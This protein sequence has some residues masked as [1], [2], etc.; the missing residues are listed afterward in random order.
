MKILIVS[1]SKGKFFH[2]KAFGEALKKLGVEYKIVNESDYGLGFPSRKI[3]NWFNSGKKFKKL[4]HDFSPDCVFVDRQARVG[5]Y[6]IEEKIKRFHDQIGYGLFYC[7][8]NKYNELKEFLL[9]LKREEWLYK[10]FEEH[11]NKEK[12]FNMYQTKSRLSA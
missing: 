1:G 8:S 7:S 3:K 9:N 6:T 10:N 11:K 4:L 2:L 5:V 12:G